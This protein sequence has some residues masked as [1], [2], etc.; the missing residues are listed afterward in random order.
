[1][2]FDLQAH[3][4]GIALTVENTL[5]AFARALEVGVSTLEFDVQITADGYAVICHDADPRPERCRDTGPAYPGDPAYPYVRRDAFVRDLTLAQVRTID[6]GSQRHPRYPEQQ[7]AP[8]ARM[9]LLSELCD[10]VRSVGADQVGFNVELKVAAADP[11]RSAPA[12]E[13]VAVVVAELRRHEMLGRTTIQSFDWGALQRIRETEPALPTYV[14]SGE[15]H[16]EPDAPGGSPWL[17]GL[18]VD[19]FPG[20]L[21][22]QYVA[23]AA[24]IGAAVVSPVHGSPYW[25]SVSDPDYRAFTTAELVDAAHAAGMKVVPYTVNDRASME[26]LIDMGVDGFITDRPDLGREV[27]TDRGLSLPPAVDAARLI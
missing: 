14:L 1:M 2:A 6:V 21:Q 4:G 12:E 7:L 9:P 11:L 18:D 26:W 13:F 17:G 27:M 3:R 24:S 22:L 20:T 8:G 16:L 5:P 19:D 15:K 23:A 10:L 25:G